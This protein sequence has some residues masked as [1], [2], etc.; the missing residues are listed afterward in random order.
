MTT[1]A[2]DVQAL[3]Q[4]TGV[5]M[6][7]AKR[8][9]EANNG[10]MEASVQWLR[11]Q[12]LAS[13]A[14]RADREASEGAV[15][16]VR[17]G[18]VA[19]IVELRSETDFVAKSE[20]FVTLADEIAAHVAAE[21]QESLAHFKANI[22]TML[23]TLKENISIGRVY[24]LEAGPGEVVDTY[25]HHQS[26]RGVNAVAVVLKGANEETAHEIAV[27]IAFAKPLYLSR[28]DVPQSDVDAER[29]TIEEITR[30]EGKPEAAMPK[31]IE[32][33]LNGWYKER[34]LLEQPYVKDEKETVQQ[35]L[36]G[37]TISAYAQ[38]VIGG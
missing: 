3:R 5:G 4:A 31:I 17:D 27:H 7:D 33:R 13:A 26:G 6:M 25:V 14:K 24:R 19:A 10:D 21:G 16:V 38:V 22:E 20:E 32:G 11:V 1:T 23:T 2:K 35:F 9:L 29:K 12:G 15:A 18:N 28:E 37:A 8:A 36:K 34:V 30:N